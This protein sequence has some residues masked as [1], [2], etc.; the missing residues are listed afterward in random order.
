MCLEPSGWRPGGSVGTVQRLTLSWCSHVH[1]SPVVRAQIA[2]PERQCPHNPA[3]ACY[4]QF[5]QL[6]AAFVVGSCSRFGVGA[7]LAPGERRSPL[8]SDFGQNSRLSPTLAPSG[9]SAVAS[10]QSVATPARIPAPFRYRGTDTMACA[11]S[12]GLLTG[13]QSCCLPGGKPADRGFRA[14]CPYP[15]G[16]HSRLLR[17][18]V[19]RRTC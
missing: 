13:R 1:T 4:A 5:W 19:Q 18:G 15:G 9:L 6:L 8:R 12:P 2:R 10:A 14:L 3:V 11:T 7:R 17:R 16:A